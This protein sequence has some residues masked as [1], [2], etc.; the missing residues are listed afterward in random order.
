MKDIEYTNEKTKS[1][2]TTNSKLFYQSS[3]QGYLVE[4]KV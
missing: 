1:L 3:K 4:N 2:L